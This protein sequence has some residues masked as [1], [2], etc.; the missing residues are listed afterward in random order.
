MR[1][2]I[3]NLNDLWRAFQ[4]KWSEVREVWKDKVA[5]EFEER[6]VGMIERDLPALLRKAEEAA[7]VLEKCERIFGDER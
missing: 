7:E 1:D 5:E 3:D 6:F 4:A 2:A